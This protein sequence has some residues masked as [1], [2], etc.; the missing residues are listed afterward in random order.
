MG[1]KKQDDL[2][3]KARTKTF[4]A[5]GMSPLHMGIKEKLSSTDIPCCTLCT[6]LDFVLGSR[7][8]M[9]KARQSSSQEDGWWW[10]GGKLGEELC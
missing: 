10:A 4:V 8:S 3:Q 9:A 6:A 1:Q 5:H 2:K 7:S